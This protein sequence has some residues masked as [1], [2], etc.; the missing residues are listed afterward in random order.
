MKNSAAADGNSVQAVLMCFVEIITV[1]FPHK[2][3]FH[4]HVLL[5]TK[6]V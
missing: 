3:F 5:S 4:Y 6:N 2:L 1:A